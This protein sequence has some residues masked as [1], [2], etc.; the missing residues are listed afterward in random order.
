M[1]SCSVKGRL[2]AKVDYWVSVLG[3]PQSLC[4]IIA[5]GYRLPFVTMRES[6]VFGNQ[7]SAITNE[8]FMSKAITELC[9]DNCVRK[10][11]TRPVVISPL[12]V[13]TNRSGKQRLVIN[14][15]YVNHFLWKEKFKYE[16]MRI[17]W[18]YFVKGHYINTFDLKSAYHHIDIH[19]DFQKYLGFQWEC[20]YFVFTVLPFG[21]ATA[22]YVFTKVLRPLVKF[23]RSKGLRTVLYIDDGIIVSHCQGSAMHNTKW[24]V[25]HW[26]MLVY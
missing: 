25:K 15:R 17:A 5:Q 14:L 1:G 20:Q 8:E 13:V 26:T 6:K 18:T 12:L 3:A 4:D 11:E 23:W 19:K 9:E 22:C 24:F 21:L 10:V 16:D 2:K 7:K